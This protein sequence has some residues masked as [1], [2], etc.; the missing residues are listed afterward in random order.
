M[1]DF[2]LDPPVPIYLKVY[3]FNVTNPEEFLQ[4]QKASLEEVGPYV[5]RQEIVSKFKK[6]IIY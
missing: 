5:Y 1:Y 4:G 2:W 3:M 6:K